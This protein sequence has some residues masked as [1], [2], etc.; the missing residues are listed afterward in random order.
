MRM[1]G[2]RAAAMFNISTLLNELMKERNLYEG[3]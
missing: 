3:F 2:A 1:R